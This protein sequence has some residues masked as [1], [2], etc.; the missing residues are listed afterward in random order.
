MKRWSLGIH[1]QRKIAKAPMATSSALLNE[2][3]KHQYRTTSC[4]RPFMLRIVGDVAVEVWYG[5]DLLNKLSIQ[6]QT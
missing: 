4:K 1:H 5:H 6:I 2:I 3:T